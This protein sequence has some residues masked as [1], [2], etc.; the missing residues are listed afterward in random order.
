MAGEERT[1][2]VFG[3]YVSVYNFKESVDDQNTVPLYYENRIPELQLTN[4]NLT[5]EIADICDRAEL[6]EDQERKL[7]RE[8]AREYHLITRDDR[9]ERVGQDI[10]AHFMG[11]GVLAKAMVISIDKATAVKTYDKVRK[12]WPAGLAQLRK[13]LAA[14]DPA[15]K[16]ELEKR[17]AYAENTDMAVVVSQSQNEIE[18]FKKKGLDIARTASGW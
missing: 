2:E 14:A 11:R 18:E 7:E 8:F 10:V 3:E 17:L 6:D 13:E 15:D 5:E 16:K 12:H 9:L 1:R 4:E